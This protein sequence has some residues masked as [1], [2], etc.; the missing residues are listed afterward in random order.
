M[1]VA[2]A[3][4]HQRLI[5]SA[6]AM[7]AVG[8]RPCQTSP[9]TGRP[10]IRR[11]CGV[12]VVVLLP[13]ASVTS[14]AQCPI[15]PGTASV[16]SVCGRV[17]RRSRRALVSVH[18]WT[19]SSACKARRHRSSSVCAREP[20]PAWLKERAARSL[21]QAVR[22]AD[23]RNMIGCGRLIRGSSSRHAGA[24]YSTASLQVEKWGEDLVER[25]GRGA[26]DADERHRHVD[27]LDRPWPWEFGRMRCYVDAGAAVVL[28]RR[29]AAPDP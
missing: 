26:V 6:R 11:R 16:M 2:G 12:P 1:V 9:P 18:R 21:S 24:T 8:P 20:M 23:G 27:R 14:P 19:A 4:S 15:E 7:S 25:V 28:L 13:A 3:A 22:S 17:L 29:S 5:A 10:R